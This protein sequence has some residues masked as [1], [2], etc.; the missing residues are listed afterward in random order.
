MLYYTKCQACDQSGS[1]EE[2]FFFNFLCIAMG[3][4]KEILGRDCF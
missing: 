1:E 3:K 4:T 2:G